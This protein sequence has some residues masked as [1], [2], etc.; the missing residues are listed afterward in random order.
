MSV[1]AQ[2]SLIQVCFCLAIVILAVEGDMCFRLLAQYG[3]LLIFV[4]FGSCC[5]VSEVLIDQQ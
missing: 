1:V 3:K 4:L 2:M 5:L